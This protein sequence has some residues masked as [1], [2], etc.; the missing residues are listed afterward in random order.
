[1]LARAL[2]PEV[3]RVSCRMQHRSTA[4]SYRCRI[5]V[6]NLLFGYC[7]SAAAVARSSTQ[8]WSQLFNR[9]VSGRRANLEYRSLSASAHMSKSCLHR[10]ISQFTDSAMPHRHATSTET[11]SL[12]SSDLSGLVFHKG[13]WTVDFVAAGLVVLLSLLVVYGAKEG[14]LFNIGDHSH[15]PLYFA[16]K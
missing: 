10:S 12:L 16:Q 2:Q 3:G 8:Y 9:C 4:C 5:E 6:A 1:M 13:G 15:T 11:L 7:V 14:S